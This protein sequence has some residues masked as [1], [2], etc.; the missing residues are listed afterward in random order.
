MSLLLV[1]VHFLGE[2]S[3]SEKVG[4]SPA[5]GQDGNDT[6]GI[7]EM[8]TGFANFFLFLCSLFKWQMWLT[9][10]FRDR[11]SLIKKVMSFCGKCLNM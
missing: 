6:T 10:S 2:T 7:G 3:G 9:E 1:R 8:S 4:G 5:S 11:G